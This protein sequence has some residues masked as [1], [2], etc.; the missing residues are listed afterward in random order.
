[1]KKG[2]T[3]KIVLITAFS[4]ILLF[5]AYIYVSFNG[6]PWKK[7]SVGKR[8]LAH[9]E[10]KYDQAFVIT[11]RRYN[12]KDGSY[13]VEVHPKDKSNIVFYSYQRN[14]DQEFIDNYPEV[15]WEEQANIDFAHI[16][17]KMFPE[18]R[19]FSLSFVQ[20][21]S[22][23]VVKGPEIPHYT[24]TSSTLMIH[25]NMAKDF[26]HTDAE[27]EQILKLIQLVKHKTNHFDLFMSYE[28]NENQDAVHNVYISINKDEI[29]NIHTIEDVKQYN[30]N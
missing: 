1:M 23:G 14:G 19:R 6:L 21:E 24:K 18:N 12:F 5:A 4:L 20:G 8:V 22:E 29:S 28:K 25:I 17:K 13:G 7:Y 9:I 3:L 15:V 2:K 10:Q 16:I 11:E 30:H 26:G 27:Y